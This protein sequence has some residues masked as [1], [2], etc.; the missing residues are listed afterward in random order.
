MRFWLSF[1]FLALLA[2]THIAAAAPLRE[3][4][5]TG[6]EQNILERVI[7]RRCGK[8]PYPIEALGEALR[9]EKNIFT[10]GAN[11]PTATD[12]LKRDPDYIRIPMGRSLA[13]GKTNLEHPRYVSEFSYIDDMIHLPLLYIGYTPVDQQLELIVW[14]DR[15]SHYDFLIVENYAHAPRLVRP[16]RATCTLCHQNEGPIFPRAP[17][18]EIE[19]NSRKLAEKMKSFRIEAGAPRF[20][21]PTDAILIDGRVRVSSAALV[22]GDFCRKLCV[23]EECRRDLLQTLISEAAYVLRYNEQGQR[24]FPRYSH[25]EFNQKYEP[26]VEASKL[27]RPSSVIPDRDPLKEI[28]SFF[29]VEISRMLDGRIDSEMYKEAFAASPLVSSYRSNIEYVGIG[30]AAADPKYPRPINEVSFF[31]RL[32]VTD[33]LKVCFKTTFEDIKGLKI[34]STKL[35]QRSADKVAL[36]DLLS[37][38]WPISKEV[39]LA[40]LKGARLPLEPKPVEPSVKEPVT[41]NFETVE[42]MFRHYCIGCHGPGAMSAGSGGIHLPL[43]NIELLKIYGGA[44]FPHLVERYLKDAI[45]PPKGAPFIPSASDRELMVRFLR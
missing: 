26:L 31:W 33:A 44:R 11:D 18:S 25:A 43:E 39:L 8:I 45:M 19:T 21:E 20:G 24:F 28:E 12:N 13:R 6:K 35:Q 30:H 1:S 29:G 5:L 41:M 22:M 2:A 32:E 7:T 34:S 9:A 37:R 3:C 27:G 36:K 15:E 10:P 40:F 4:A 23:G 42:Q 38:P 16:Q 17:W 14:S